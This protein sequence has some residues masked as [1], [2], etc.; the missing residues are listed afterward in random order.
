MTSILPIDF[1]QKDGFFQPK[2]RELHDLAVEFAAREIV[3][4]TNLTRFNKVWVSLEDG[5]C[6]GIA[7]YVVRA[8]VPMFRT[9]TARATTL[10]ARR[11]NDFFADQG[12][13]GQ[14]VLLHLS[15]KEAPEQ[16]CANWQAELEAA[17]AVPAD[18]Y[19]ITVK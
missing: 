2:D 17:G 18:R 7:G 3:G 19:T 4:E 13:R 16:R 8:D 10:M 9:T 5:A 15:S 6:T 1:L 12:L 14:E 11:L